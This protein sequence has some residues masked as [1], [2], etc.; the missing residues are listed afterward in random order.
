VL[1][2]LQSVVLANDDVWAIVDG[3][4]GTSAAYQWNG[5][6]WHRVRIP[7]VLEGSVVAESPRN[8]W[9]AGSG[10]TLLT[11]VVLHWSH[12]RWSRVPAPPVADPYVPAASDGH[13][14]LWFNQFAHYEHGS[15]LMPSA[16]P[17][18]HGCG[19]GLGGGAVAAIPGTSAAWLSDGCSRTATSRL[20]P[21]I[22][23][24]GHL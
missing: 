6:V 5:V 11:S 24:S 16:F 10:H 8:V 14:G 19:F 13:G 2:D 23:V 15:W 7:F 9:I 18:W 17:S 20:I 22:A 21:V 1:G 4:T 12:G 3:N